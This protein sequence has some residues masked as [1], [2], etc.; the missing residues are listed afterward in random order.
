M[1][2]K[3][4]IDL[5]NFEFIDESNNEQQTSVQ[6]KYDVMM[7]IDEDAQTEEERK[8][9]LL[10]EEEEEEEEKEEEGKGEGEDAGESD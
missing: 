10:L 4:A 8:A 7:K 9:W 5:D 1:L 6:V 3:E 2:N